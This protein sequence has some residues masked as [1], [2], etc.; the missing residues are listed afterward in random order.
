MWVYLNDR[1]VQA[2]QA[3]ISVFDR[4]FLYGDGV[5]ETVRIHDG[6]PVWLDRHLARL[7]DSCRQIGLSLPDK[8][9]PAIFQKVIDKNRVDRAAIRLTLSRGT[10]FPSPLMGESR[11]EGGGT[12]TV[13][14]FH[15][16]L[17]QVT[18]SQRRKG[19]KL[20]LTTI[21]R[22]SPRSHP[23]QAKTL[24]YL[25][26]LLAKQ[27]AAERGAFDGL[28]VTTDGYVAEC[29][30]SNV[31]FIKGRTL[32]TPSLACGVLPGITRG[33]V[34]DMAP[35]LDL[36]IREGRYR[37]AFLYKADECFLTGSGVGIL[38]VQAIDGHVFPRQTARS[39]ATAL[40]RRYKHLLR[41]QS[42]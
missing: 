39:W 29:S 6:R 11:G 9:W 34:L 7:A 1:I 16:P 27:E 42:R 30:M 3:R 20:T 24:N 15:R 41:T 36:Q 26:S 13:V 10:L 18:P 32:Y 38:P 12:P 23:T 37:P 8:P 40:Q 22:L 25:N 5:F 31:F 21:C 14:L 19:I 2:E 17:P 4:G 28:M 35:S 33:V